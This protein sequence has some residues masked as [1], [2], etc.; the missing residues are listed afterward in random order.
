M[1]STQKT[2]TTQF[3]IFQN[4]AYHEDNLINSKGLLDTKMKDYS[5]I[6]N[7][8][9]PSKKL[10]LERERNRDIENT[11]KKLL[12]KIYSIIYDK[13]KQIAKKYRPEETQTSKFFNTKIS[14]HP[15]CEEHKAKT[16]NFGQRRREN[17]RIC[18]D[19]LFLL[20]RLKN[21]KPRVLN[22]EDAKNHNRQT[23]KYAQNI[24]IFD[25]NNRPKSVLTFNDKNRLSPALDKFIQR[26]E[27]S[28]KSNLSFN[29]N[30]EFVNVTSMLN[31]LPESNYIDKP[32][33]GRS[34]KIWPIDNNSSF[35][36]NLSFLNQGQTP[37][38]ETQNQNNHNLEEKDQNYK[39][40][41]IFGQSDVNNRRLNINKI[42]AQSY[43]IINRGKNYPEINKDISRIPAKKSF[44][45][46]LFEDK[47]AENELMIS[48][49]IM[50][51][52]FELVGSSY[53]NDE[54]FHLASHNPNA[55]EDDTF[56]VIDTD[57]KEIKNLEESYV[58]A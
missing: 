4:K 51:G 1:N 14:F 35:Q 7:S 26:H 13:D 29:Y 31:D 2:K 18:Q 30:N 22:I 54:N 17:D 33:R 9:I 5:H 46:D 23:N 57:N 15:F 45:H 19:N 6:L 21:S 37:S 48:S 34:A 28:K 11:N 39:K 3:L 12:N 8:Q 32:L 20:N 40:K 50:E 25:P 56:R 47:E 42:R 58:Q 49:S 43:G 16:L 24:R 55:Y 38:A 27:K 44:N 53:H 10:F 36:L 41:L 52:N